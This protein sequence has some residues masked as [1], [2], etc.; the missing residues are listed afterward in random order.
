MHFVPAATDP[1]PL[2]W[3]VKEVAKLLRVSDRY[4]LMLVARGDIPALRL[5]R[6]VLI[7]REAFARM[8]DAVGS[9]RTPA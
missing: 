9:E 5:G 3:T 4:V 6:R 2:V 1:E 8:L 7:P